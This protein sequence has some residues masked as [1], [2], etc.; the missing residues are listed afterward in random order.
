MREGE[1]IRALVVED[2]RDMAEQLRRILQRKFSF[3]VEVAHDCAGARRM[4]REDGFEIVTLDFMLPD[5]RGLD[6]LEEIT[7]GGDTRVIMI[8]GH[9]DEETAVRSFRSSASGYVVKDRNLVSRL[10]EAIEKALMEIDLKRAEEE[11]K[12]REE[13]FRSL[14]EKAIDMITVFIPDGTITYESP[15]IER[16][17]GFKPDE[18][19][20]KNVFD[21]IHPDDVPR[22]MGIVARSLGV[23][24]ATA[25]AEL[26]FRHKDGPWRT[27]ESVGRNL[28]EDPSVNGIV[29]NSRDV[30][31]RKQSEERLRRYREQLEQLVEERTIE[32]TQTNAQLEQ[33]I[34]ERKQA[35]SE[36]QKRAERLADFL[37]VASHELRHPVSVVK[38]YATMLS[39]YLDRMDPDDLHRILAALDVSV[40][41]LTYFVEELMQASLVEEGR[42]AVDRSENELEPL[43]SEVARDMRARSFDNP[44]DIDVAAEARAALVDPGRFTQLITILMDN[45][46]KFSPASSPI[47]VTA[48]RDGAETVVSVE[49]RGI[50]IPEQY[51]ETIFDR[52]AQVEEV[53][54]HS[55]IGLGLGLYLAKQIADAHGGRI[56]VE[57]REG[58]GSIF[59]FTIR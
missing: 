25:V 4:M 3:E 54:H 26:R 44:V 13:H 38:G 9:G 11:L 10:V 28:L 18:L 21:Y 14:I 39:G 32:L 56:W 58:G 5:G 29:V 27:F 24:G 40:D 6:L 50:G 17:L 42:F 33:E 30:T 36:L 31:E 45:A 51:R 12:R 41:R 52:F 2:E 53:K 35:Q 23:P 22:I 34:A 55:S 47:K 1:K 20:G 48:R 57:P 15:S 19:V 43:I 46:I 16:I 7:T 8:T 37:T 49:D 59:R